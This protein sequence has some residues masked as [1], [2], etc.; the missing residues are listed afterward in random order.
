MIKYRSPNAR[1]LGTRGMAVES[2][3]GALLNNNGEEAI[4]TPN[5]VDRP[6]VCDC[7]V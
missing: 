1:P 3:T 2:G 7:G 6:A 5:P 4:A